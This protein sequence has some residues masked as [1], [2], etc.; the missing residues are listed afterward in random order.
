MNLSLEDYRYFN[1]STVSRISLPI[2]PELQLLATD[3]KQQL[4]LATFKMKS[5][6]PLLSYYLVRKWSTHEQADKYT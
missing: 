2:Q 4:H 6:D 5:R 3:A 1:I